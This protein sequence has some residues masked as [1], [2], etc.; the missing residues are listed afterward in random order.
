[1]NPLVQAVQKKSTYPLNK[2]VEAAKEEVSF[3]KLAYGYARTS[4]DPATPYSDM[5]ENWEI[6]FSA[7]H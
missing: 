3:Y 6:P 5:N 2:Y 4:T 7:V 1:V